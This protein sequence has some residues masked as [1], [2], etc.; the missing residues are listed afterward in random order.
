MIHR[1]LQISTIAALPI[2]V[3]IGLCAQTAEVKS[4]RQQQ[5]ATSSELGPTNERKSLDV[6]QSVKGNQRQITVVW[7]GQ[8]SPSVLVIN[9]DY[10]AGEQRL[11]EFG[12]E[13]RSLYGPVVFRRIGTE[14]TARL[15]IDETTKSELLSHPANWGSL[16]VYVVP[17]VWG[18]AMK[19]ADPEQYRGKVPYGPTGSKEFTAADCPEDFQ[20]LGSQSGSHH[21]AMFKGLTLASVETPENGWVNGSVITTGPASMIITDIKRGSAPASPRE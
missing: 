5:S 21:S 7:S 1:A 18:V 17:R 9:V 6:T 3:A 19:S 20:L 16:G 11:A 10:G 4:N 8:P 13:G 14:G 12:D 2:A 15:T